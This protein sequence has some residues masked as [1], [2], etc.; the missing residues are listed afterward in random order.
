MSNFT[1]TKTKIKGVYII[2]MKTDGDHR[3]Y[4]METYK[5]WHQT[6]HRVV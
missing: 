2:D 4:F 1:F 6:Y 5:A 3:G